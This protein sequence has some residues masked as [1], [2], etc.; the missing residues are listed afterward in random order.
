[1]I[2]KKTEKK[3]FSVGRVIELLL[4]RPCNS[5]V[6]SADTAILECLVLSFFDFMRPSQHSTTFPNAA[7]CATVTELTILPVSNQTQAGNACRTIAWVAGAETG[8]KEGNVSQVQGARCKYR[9]S[10]RG[11]RRERMLPRYWSL[12]YRLCLRNVQLSK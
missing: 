2:Q 9:E 7:F 11:M 3:E 4:S 5:L 10:A 12:H 8:G 1:M 6:G